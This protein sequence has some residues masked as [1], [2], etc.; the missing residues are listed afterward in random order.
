M[1]PIPFILEFRLKSLY[2]LSKS[3]Y[4]LTPFLVRKGGDLILRGAMPLLNT[5]L[6]SYRGKFFRIGFALSRPL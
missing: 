4:P 3:T 5:P 1:K 2:L 6:L